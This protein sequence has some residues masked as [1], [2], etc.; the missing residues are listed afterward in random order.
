MAQ[1]GED[2][3]PCSPGT[4]ALYALCAAW[5]R[6]IAL[7]GVMLSAAVSAANALQLPLVALSITQLD[8]AEQ[9]S[10]AS[11]VQLEI[12]TLSSSTALSVATVAQPAAQVSA[13]SQEAAAVSP[14]Q[15]RL[16]RIAAELGIGSAAFHRVPPEYYEHELPWRAEYLCAA[17]VEQAF[18]TEGQLVLVSLRQ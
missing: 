4:E 7:S 3:V 6:R 15:Q 13:A 2:A 8:R 18:N 5:E 9:S 14:M 16:A 10:V 17:S 12:A 1:C 11:L